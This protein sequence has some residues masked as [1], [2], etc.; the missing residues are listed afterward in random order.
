M[1]ILQTEKGREYSPEKKKNHEQQHG[2]AGRNGT[3]CG[4]EGKP[5]GAVTG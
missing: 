2:E 3:V 4:G 1:N 5:R